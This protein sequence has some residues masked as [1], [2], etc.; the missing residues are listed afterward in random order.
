MDQR[1]RLGDVVKMDKPV[2]GAGPPD[3]KAI[4]IGFLVTHPESNEVW[5]A[6]PDEKKDLEHTTT[7]ESMTPEVIEGVLKTARAKFYK[8]M[9]D[10]ANYF[11]DLLK[12]MTNE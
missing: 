1:F 12:M 8:G 3:D 11:V 6:W 5:M 7:P 9:A 10:G 2:V 4:I